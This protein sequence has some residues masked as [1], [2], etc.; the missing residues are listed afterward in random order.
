[1]V[2]LK[3]IYSDRRIHISIDTATAHAPNATQNE[4]EISILQSKTTTCHCTAYTQ[5]VTKSH[6]Q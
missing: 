4:L 3:S 2:G 5:N 1:M 6:P